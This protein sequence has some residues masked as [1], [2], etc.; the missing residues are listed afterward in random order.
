MEMFHEFFAKGTFTRSINTTFLVLIPKKG[1]VEDLKDFKKINL[2]GSL[3]KL[4]AKVLGNRLKKVVS[5][6]QNAF[7]E[8]CQITNASLIAN[9]VIDH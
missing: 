1:G 2:L 3:Y 5:Y 8:G 7:V 9:E 4:L 6:A